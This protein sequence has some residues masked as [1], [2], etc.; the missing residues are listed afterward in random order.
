MD[1]ENWMTEHNVFDQMLADEVGVT[2]P[3]VSR[4]RRG[5]V[6]PSLGVALKIWYFTGRAIKLE[7]LLPS[8]VRRQFKAAPVRPYKSFTEQP[9]AEAPPAPEPVEDNPRK[10][11][12]RR[13]LKSP[14]SA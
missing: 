4:V 1:L 14:A 10:L 7:S 3:Y 5:L 2:R 12:A 11:A 13:A 9:P 8:Q 6:H